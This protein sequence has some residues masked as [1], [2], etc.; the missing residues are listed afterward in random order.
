M[1]QSFCWCF[2]DNTVTADTVQHY[3]DE[4]LG[5]MELD[6][7]VCQLEH[8]SHT[9]LQGLIR[10]KRRVSFSVIKA[11]FAALGANPHI[12]VM[13][14][15][16]AQ[17]KA[18][19]MKPESRVLG[20]WEEGSEF[21]DD[22]IP[23]PDRQVV[24]IFGPP[25]TGKT[26]IA[27]LIGEYL[28]PNSVYNVPGRAKN[29]NG[30]WLGDYSGQPIAIIEEFNFFEDFTKDQW[31]LLLDGVAHPLPGRAGGQTVQW[32]PSLIFLLT[33]DAIRPSHPFRSDPA[34]LYRISHLI[35]YNVPAH[36]KAVT[37]QMTVSVDDLELE[38][39]DRQNKKRKL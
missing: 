39:Y 16:Y 32:I 36:P 14:G 23:I 24:C 10:Y 7:Y 12:E 25:K 38:A 15:T 28:G 27:R 18:Y 11:A 2:T 5:R 20:P 21:K 1:V 29:S 35:F 26:Y 33:N 34:F 6:H 22:V 30:R 8:V 9:H 3:R 4:V 31:K 13:K 19:C 17:A 37:R